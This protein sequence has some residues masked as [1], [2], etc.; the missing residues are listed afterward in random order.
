MNENSR[1]GVEPRMFETF[2]FSGAAAL[3]LVWLIA[4]PIA[5]GQEGADSSQRVGVVPATSSQKDTTKKTGESGGYKDMKKKPNA[6]V[7]AR[8]ASRPEIDNTMG[9]GNCPVKPCTTPTDW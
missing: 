1:H 9:L 7:P 6:S 2:I 3:G 8:P 4:T 5:F